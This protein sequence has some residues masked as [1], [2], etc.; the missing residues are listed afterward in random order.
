MIEE[1]QYVISFMKFGVTYRAELESAQ[2]ALS[3][4]GR[5]LEEEGVYITGASKLVKVD[6]EWKSGNYRRD[7]E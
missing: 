4:I 2:E 5:L 3:L 6:G 7:G 1:V